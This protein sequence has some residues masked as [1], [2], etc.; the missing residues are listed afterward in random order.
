MIGCR[1]GWMDGWMDGSGC[2]MGGCV[3]GRLAGCVIN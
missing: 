2:W 1:P 3:V